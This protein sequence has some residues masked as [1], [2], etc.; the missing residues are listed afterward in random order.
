MQ[1]AEVLDV[2]TTPAQ[3]L[4]PRAVTVLL[5]EQ[6]F[7]GEINVAVK[8]ADVPGAR[9]ATLNTVLG[10]ACASTTV[11]L[12]SV[13]LPGLLTVPEKVIEFPVTTDVAGQFNVTLIS[14]VPE[15]AHVAKAA[16]VT[17]LPEQL[18]L[19]RAV[20]VEVMEQSVPPGTV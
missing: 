8:L 16:L 4:L 18:S 11:T 13:T 6:A 17:R 14:G 3:V 15:T 5:T 7:T 20:R 10:E 19:P 1:V 9:L 2:A 12:M